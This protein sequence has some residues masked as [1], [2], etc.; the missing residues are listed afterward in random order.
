MSR[1]KTNLEF[2]VSEFGNDYPA[3]MIDLARMNWESDE[4]LG[5]FVAVM[6]GVE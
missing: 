6:K 4:D 3:L 2:L 5:R 1:F